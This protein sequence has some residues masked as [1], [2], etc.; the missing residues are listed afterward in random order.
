MEVGMRGVIP[1][2]ATVQL[3]LLSLLFVS[4]CSST[5]QETDGEFVLD[6]IKIATA[7]E[8]SAEEVN[9]ILENNTD[10]DWYYVYISDA[11]DENWGED[12]LGEEIMAAGG[13]ITIPLAPSTYDLMIEDED[14]DVCRQ[15]GIEVQGDMT[16]GYDNGPYLDCISETADSSE[17][18][19]STA[20]SS[21]VPFIITNNSSWGIH[22]VYFSQSDEDW[23]ADQ[24]G[25]MILEPGGSFTINTTP[26]TY[27]L[28]MEDEDGD[29]CIDMG[30]VVRTAGSWN[31]GENGWLE[32]IANQ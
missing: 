3:G 31:I 19:G 30:I 14:S 26:G 2:L 23:G 28:R 21:S 27:D 25:G 17:D 32:C 29:V 15:F 7:T 1:Q 11:D 10:Y 6:D 20:S 9:L 18:S 8:A 5:A 13:S 24:L 12:Q 4:A 16:F 22:Y